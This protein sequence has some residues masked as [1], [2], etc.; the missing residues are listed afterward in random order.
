MW[1][2][3]VGE[4]SYTGLKDYSCKI[5][6]SVELCQMLKKTKQNKV[7]DRKRL[8]IEVCTKWEMCSL[9][10]LAAVGARGVIWLMLCTVKDV[11][12]IPQ[13]HT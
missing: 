3:L 1:S 12:E 13:D 7:F 6:V 8:V 5:K 4:T 9:V 2:L 10:L 11:V